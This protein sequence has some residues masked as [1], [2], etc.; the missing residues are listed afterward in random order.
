MSYNKEAKL[1]KANDGG[2]PSDALILEQMIIHRQHQQTTAFI[3]SNPMINLMI[4][5]KRT[6]KLRLHFSAHKNSPTL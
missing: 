4:S 2:E 5:P 6:A 3:Y 1:Q